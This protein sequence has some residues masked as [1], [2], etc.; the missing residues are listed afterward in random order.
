MEFGEGLFQHIAWK[1][2]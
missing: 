1:L 2:W